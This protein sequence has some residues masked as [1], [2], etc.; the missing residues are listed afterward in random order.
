MTT[1]QDGQMM[2]PDPTLVGELVSQ[3][4]RRTVSAERFRFNLTPQKALNLLTA[5]YSVEVSLRNR[6]FILDENTLSALN[7]LATAITLPKPRFGIMCCGTCGNGKTTL[8]YAFRRAV[9]F[10]KGKQHF[11]FLNEEYFFGEPFEILTAREILQQSQE[12]KRFQEIKQRP[13]LGIDDLGT[14]PLEQQ[15]YG[16]VMTPLVELFE[17][18]YNN[19]L[20]TFITTNLKG[21][22]KDSQAETIRGKYKERIADRFN[23]WLHVIPFRNITYRKYE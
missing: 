12:Y 8:M 16:N 14:E 2:S 4:S 21:S 9:H 20:F 13:L 6:E 15:N 10:L 18:R 7:Q 1:S 23:E 3:I 19:Q 11:G 17:Y 5:A 22:S